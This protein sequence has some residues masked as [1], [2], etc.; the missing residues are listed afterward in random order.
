MSWESLDKT[1]AEY[2]AKVEADEALLAEV[3]MR[4]LRNKKILKQA[5]ERAKKK[6]ICLSNEMREAGEE[7]DATSGNLDYPAAA[8]SI[9]F[10]PTI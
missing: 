3:I 4:L 5:D 2:A 7:V 6:A 8:I 10:S 9:G 1:R